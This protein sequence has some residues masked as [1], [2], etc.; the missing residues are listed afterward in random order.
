MPTLL[1]SLIS[2]CGGKKCSSGMWESE[3][4]IADESATLALE[5]EVSSLPAL[6]LLICDVLMQ[7]VSGVK[8]F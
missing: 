1:P 4:I 5:I 6:V 8:Q 7:Y 2:S 3:I